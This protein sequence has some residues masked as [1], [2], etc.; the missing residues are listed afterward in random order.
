MYTGV[1]CNGNP[2]IMIKKQENGRHGTEC[3]GVVISVRGSVTARRPD[4]DPRVL[5]VSD[6]VFPDDQVTTGEGSAITM[7]FVNGTKFNLGANTEAV[8]DREVFDLSLL[9]DLANRPIAPP[10]IQ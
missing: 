10:I 9:D 2:A 4:E 5:R 6:P 3:I 8:L 1:V 7:W